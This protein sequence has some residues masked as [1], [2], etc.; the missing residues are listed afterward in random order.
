MI[1]ITTKNKSRLSQIAIV[2]TGLNPGLPRVKHCGIG[3]EFKWVFKHTG[4][5]FDENPPHL[6]HYLFKKTKH[7]TH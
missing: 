1:F 7:F 3:T 4:R 6:T 2:S 5:V